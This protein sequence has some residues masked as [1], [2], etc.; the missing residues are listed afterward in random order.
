M[1]YVD[2]WFGPK[3]MPEPR[4]EYVAW[5]DIMGTESMMRF[6]PDIATTNIGKMIVATIE[7]DH[8]Q[9]TEF[10]PVLDGIYFTHEEEGELKAIFFDI[11]LRFAQILIQRFEE[12][13][14]P[15][16][17]LS[18]VLR[19]GI[20]YGDVYHGVDFED[21]AISDHHFSEAFLA[22]KPV[23]HA[24][25]SEATAPPFGFNLHSS[26]DAYA[27]SG[28]LA[29]FARGYSNETRLIE[30]W[31]SENYGIRMKKALNAY[32]DYYN[33][34]PVPEYPDEKI[35]QHRDQVNDYFPS[36]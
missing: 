21:S 7:T 9:G 13:D 25:Y 14:T 35:Q 20:A 6:S 23:A 24:H 8:P 26:A 28:D 27:E 4:Q 32:F 2:P 10:Y 15:G 33:G 1:P 19:A 17:H 30:W 31:Q 16:V 22:G 36:N 12:D 29:D 3:Q 18:P 34:R 5:L 11:F